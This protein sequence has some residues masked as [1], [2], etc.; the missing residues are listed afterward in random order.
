MSQA[1]FTPIRIYSSSTAAAVPLAGNLDNTNGAELAINI[2]DGRLYYKDNTNTVQIIGYKV[3]PL[4]AGGTGA[5][6]ASAARTNLG[7][8]TVGSNFFTLANPSAV[9]FPRIN[10]DNSVSALD[11]ATFRSAIGAG[12]G[13]GSVTSVAGTGTVNGITL[14]GTV[15]STGNLTLGGTLSGVSLT[16]QVTGTLPTANGGTG[17]VNGTVAKLATTGFSVEESGGKLVF[18]Y[19]ATTLGSIDSSGNFIVIGN[20]T[21]YGTP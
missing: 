13:G 1:G 5:T 17:N 18:K 8:T 19:G 11:A 12:T 3:T 4:T 20:V 15:T 16:S 2:T 10:A 9:T 7:G 21:A 14:T 6:S